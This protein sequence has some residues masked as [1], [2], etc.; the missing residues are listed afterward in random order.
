MRSNFS[1]FFLLLIFSVTLF[2]CSEQ[3]ETTAEEESCEA[4]KVEVSPINPNGDSEL[5]LLMRKLYDDAD[6][7]KLL[8]ESG[9][10][11]I[12]DKYIEELQRVHTAVP[13]DPNVKSPEFT[14][15]NE[16]LINQAKA[17]KENP[18]NKSEAF[19]LLVNRCID[20]HNV[21]CPGPIKKIKKLTIKQ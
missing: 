12:T 10:G 20:C 17:V 16:L 6:S 19:N 8:I 13:T 11:N 4:D 2:S 7:L 1:S 21:F 18:E 15:F 9:E 14:A 3:V 5:A